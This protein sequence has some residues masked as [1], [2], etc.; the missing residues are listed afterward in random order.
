MS[1]PELLPM[2]LV[3]ISGPQIVSAVF[4]AVSRRWR[5][6]SGAFIAGAL[7]ATCVLAAVLFALI[8]QVH[9]S[10]HSHTGTSRDIDIG[11]L[12]LLALLAASV[13]RRRGNGE[14]PKWMGALTDAKP[15]FAFTLGVLL[16][17]LFPGDILATAICAARV[18]REGGHLTGL[19]PFVALTI[20]LLAIPAAMT[21]MLGRRAEVILPKVR[22]WMTSNSWIVSEI[23]IAFF[24]ALTLSD[25][26]K[27]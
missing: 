17:L 14:P 11:A 3:M 19:V 24:F 21:L 9:T 27:S 4:F 7:L 2:A 23:V 5:A 10:G 15:R 13:Y 18:V 6:N 8:K 1:F 25:V 16:F 22:D 20:L 26:L 12:V